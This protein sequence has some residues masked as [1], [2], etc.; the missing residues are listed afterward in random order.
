MK[1]IV[2]DDI[3]VC[4]NPFVF[5]EFKKFMKIELCLNRKILCEKHA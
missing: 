4:R 3:Y 1:I 2:L 5:L